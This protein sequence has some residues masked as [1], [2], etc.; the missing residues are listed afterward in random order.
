MGK[1]VINVASSVFNLAGDVTKRPNVLKNTILGAV[2][3]VN[4]SSISWSVAQSYLTGYG[5][6][7]RTFNNWCESSGYSAF[8]GGTGS[9]LSV[10]AEAATTDL[11]AVLDVPVGAVATIESY[12]VISGNPIPNATAYLETNYPAYVDQDWVADYNPGMD[13]M[14]VTAVDNSWT[15][16]YGSTGFNA[17]AATLEVYYSL[18]QLNHSPEY[19]SGTP[20]ILT[21]TSEFEAT[22]G[23]NTV[24]EVTLPNQTIEL[25]T[26]A[27]STKVYSDGRPDEV[28]VTN[29][30][31]TSSAFT[32]VTNTY[33]KEVYLGGTTTEVKTRTDTRIDSQAGIAVEGTT[34]TVVN[35]PVDIG[36]G[37]SYVETVDTVPEALSIVVSTVV[38]SATITNISRT[39][40][41]LHVYHAG[42]GSTVLDTLLGAGTTIDGDF[43]PFIPARINNVPVDQTNY[44]TT[45]VWAKKAFK[46]ATGTKGFDEILTSLA[47]NPDVAELDYAYI[48]FGVSLN[49]VTNSGK[50]YLYEFFKMLLEN[51]AGNANFIAQQDA[52]NTTKLINDNNAAWWEAQSD[53]NNASY[54]LSHYVEPVSNVQLSQSN[55]SIGSQNNPI[56]NYNIQIHWTGME[57]I[58][59]TG[60][61]KAGAKSNEYWWGTPPTAGSIVGNTLIWQVTQTTWKA[62]TIAGLKHV[63]TIYKGKDV[64]I[65]DTE[66]FEDF[67]ESGFIVPM[68]S[69]LFRT[70]RLVPRTQLSTACLYL[71]VNTY[72]ERKK[73]WYESDFF[74]FVLVVV[75]I[76]IA[77]YTGGFSL[78]GG[79]LLGSNA[80]IGSAIGLQGTAGLIAGA[81]ANAVAASLLLNVIQ[82]ASV[83]VFGEQWGTIIGAIIGIATMTMLS[84]GSF[85]Q[86][87]S[88][89]GLLKLSMA[90][91]DA[92]KDYVVTKT[93]NLSAEATRLHE[94]YQTKAKA[95]RE[96]YLIEFGG[97]DVILD[98]NIF[99]GSLPRN[100]NFEDVDSFI[101]RTLLSSSDILSISQSQ[102]YNF[103]ESKVT[104]P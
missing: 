70:L 24:S 55:I 19:E 94:E 38:D 25:T 18:V 33:T 3:S 53:S 17:G 14:T 93:E 34:T 81:A 13:T 59:G 79:G 56:M 6:K 104:L 101:A 20:T 73:K 76:A 92:Y 96:K 46:K 78:S 45:Y 4:T 51:G 62:I 39:A 77:V 68:H 54:G 98:P 16:N 9:Q 83:K 27:T 49:T 64:T 66:A 84:T 8:M 75:V 90:A 100:T 2:L 71:M 15:V 26:T 43:T 41:N 57:E 40:N 11:L 22:T 28:V 35:P 12:K 86:L 103:V 47:D 32:K 50:E 48:I 7:F 72:Q 63:N 61:A 60:L 58:E 80:A 97:G 1:Y 85:Q 31:E 95:L 102:V 10:N 30:D 44:P 21:A 82:Y 5:I 69:G 29:S 99:T 67:E 74:K 65:T 52:A 42:E 89:K 23:W 87:T 91:T 36:G 37:V 88:P